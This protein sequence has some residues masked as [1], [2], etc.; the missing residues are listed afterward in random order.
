M[1]DSHNILVENKERILQ[2][3]H[4]S[5]NTF[6]KQVIYY[7]KQERESL[8]TTSDEN[9]NRTIEKISKG[10]DTKQVANNKA[11]EILEKLVQDN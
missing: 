6:H 4:D 3:I 9:I 2:T 11:S 10:F 5:H 1:D 7:L 8:R